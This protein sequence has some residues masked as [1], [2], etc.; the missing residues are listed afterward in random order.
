MRGWYQDELTVGIE[1]LLGPTLTVGLKGTYR[2]L[3]NVLEDRCDLDYSSPETGFSACGLMNPGLERRDSRAGTFP[4]CNGLDGPWYECGIDPG[5]A[6]PP[7][8]RIYRGIELFA[9]KSVGTSLWLQASYVYSSLRGNYDGG[10]NQGAYGQTWP[11]INVDFDYPQMWHNGYGILA[12]DRPNR[13]RLDGYW[14][15]PWRLSSG[16]QAFVESGAPLN[17]LGYF[18]EFYGSDVFLVPRGSEG[19]LPTLWGTNLTLSYPIAIGPATVTLQAYLF[20]VFNKQIAISRDEEWSDQQPPDYPASIFDPNQEQNNPEYGKVT[21]RSDP[22]VFR[23]AVR[24]S[25]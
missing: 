6:T 12:L 16:L 18:N 22:R 20:N 8:S 2:T 13:F 4:T 10:V 1:R 7:V 3:R 9:R 19:R 25:F 14:V 17:R 24:V 11:G 15:T 5:P 21:G 23:A